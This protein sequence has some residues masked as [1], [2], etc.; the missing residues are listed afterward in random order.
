MKTSWQK[1]LNIFPLYSQEVSGRGRPQ[2][3]PAAADFPRI[4]CLTVSRNHKVFLLHTQ[5]VSK[6]YGGY[7]YISL[8]RASSE[9]G[10]FQ[11]YEVEVY[12]GE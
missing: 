6:I 9:D 10:Y 7:V 12:M 2:V 8:I 11:L 5:C 3:G 1:I 4:V